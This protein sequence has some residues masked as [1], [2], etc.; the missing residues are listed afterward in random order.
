MLPGSQYESEK[1]RMK[2]KIKTKFR[3]IF[4]AYGIYDGQKVFETE[5]SIRATKDMSERELEGFKILHWLIYFCWNTGIFKPILFFMKQNA[6]NPAKV[7]YKLLSTNHPLLIE[8]FSEMKK[9]SLAEWFETKEDMIQYY[10]Q[11]ENFNKLINNFT[12]LNALWVANVYHNSEIILVLLN[13]IA[14]LTN[15]EIDIESYEFQDAWIDLLK[16]VDRLL[17]RDLLQQ[18]FF[19]R[20]TYNGKALSCVLCDNN[21][22]TK[23]T[24]EVEIF[25]TKEDVAFCHKHL[26]QNGISDLSLKNITRFLEI[27]GM[28]KLTNRI[29]TAYS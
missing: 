1:D 18:E 25:R 2:Y 19:L 14:R 16:I 17:C 11:Q 9:S 5:E 13:E 29:K 10:N 12:K 8:M 6:V 28:E 23:K 27:G 26:C 7:L 22:A 15:I 20:E 4:G 21:L 24:I 3:P